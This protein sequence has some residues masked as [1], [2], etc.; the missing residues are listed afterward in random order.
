MFLPC[1]K[2]IMDITVTSP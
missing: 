1:A 2:Y